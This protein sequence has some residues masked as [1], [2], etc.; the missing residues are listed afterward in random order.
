A[1]VAPDFPGPRL[2]AVGVARRVV[3]DLGAGVGLPPGAVD[4]C[5]VGQVGTIPGIGGG[6]DDDV[7]AAHV[8]IVD[9]GTKLAAK[10]PAGVARA[11]EG[12]CRA[13]A[14]A[15]RHELVGRAEVFLC[16]AADSVRRVPRGAWKF[17][18]K[19]FGTPVYPRA[20]CVEHP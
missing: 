2:A 10:L 1:S 13:G 11:R 17:V 8:V 6:T 15:E 5:D 16:D 3:T 14:A 20:V 9:E 7:R 18:R 4:E 19:P 12:F